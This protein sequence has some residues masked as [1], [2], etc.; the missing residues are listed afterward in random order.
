MILSWIVCH[1]SEGKRHPRKRSKSPLGTENHHDQAE[2]L[3]HQILRRFKT[4]LLRRASFF[5]SDNS[6]YTDD[7]SRHVFNEQ[8]YSNKNTQ[9]SKSFVS[10]EKMGKSAVGRLY[11]AFSWSTLWRFSGDKIKNSAKHDLLSKGQYENH[12]DST[13]SMI[14]RFL[15]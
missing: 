2:R 15:C 4:Y 12:D 14:G 7:E 9:Y 13:V 10:L 3:N 6:N 5:C 8:T 1:Q 11:F